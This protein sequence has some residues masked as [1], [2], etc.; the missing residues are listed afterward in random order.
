[1]TALEIAFV[2]IFFAALLLAYALLARERSI[3][4][5]ACD[6]RDVELRD[7]LGKAHEA[8]HEARIDIAAHRDGIGGLERRLVVVHTKD[9]RSIRGVMV[10]VHDDCLVLGSAAYLGDPV[11][12]L[13]GD[14]IVPRSSVSWLQRL[15]DEGAAE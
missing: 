10:G 4:R 7:A 15:D 8:L 3:Y 12:P 9:D 5:A 2:P 1:M 14:V 6:R 13:G 11:A